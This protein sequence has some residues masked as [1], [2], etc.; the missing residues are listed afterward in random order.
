MMWSARKEVLVVLLDVRSRASADIS[1]VGKP[2]KP[3]RRSEPASYTRGQQ[4]R[5]LLHEGD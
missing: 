2:H 4:L 3:G 5:V 1:N